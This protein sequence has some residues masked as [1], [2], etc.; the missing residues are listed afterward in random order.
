MLHRAQIPKVRDHFAHLGFSKWNAWL[1]VKITRAVG[2]MA[3]AWVFAVI[4]LVSLPAAIKSGDPV[5][6][7]QWLSSVFIQLV[8]LSIIMVGQRVQSGAADQR[9]EATYLDTEEILRRLDEL[10]VRVSAL[11][12]DARITAHIDANND[13]LAQ[14]ISE[15]HDH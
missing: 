6:V 10:A 5:V 1:A 11:D 13:Q 9:A 7:V 3:C 15:Q 8:L 2:T 14:V 4:A 12:I